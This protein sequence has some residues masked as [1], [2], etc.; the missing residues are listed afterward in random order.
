MGGITMLPVLMAVMA[1]SGLATAG[2]VKLVSVCVRVTVSSIAK[3][4]RVKA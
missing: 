4:W 2:I 1:F 3:R